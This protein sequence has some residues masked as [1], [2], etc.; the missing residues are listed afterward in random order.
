VN[1]LAAELLAR[2]FSKSGDIEYRE[3][4]E[5]ALEFTIGRQ[6]ED[7][8]GLMERRRLRAGST[9]FTPALILVSAQAYS[10]TPGYG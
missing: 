1:L 8:R 6:H 3:A 7:G 10:P 2:V 4:S 9:I 5:R